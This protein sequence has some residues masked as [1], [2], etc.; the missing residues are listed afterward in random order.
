[1]RE[2]PVLKTFLQGRWTRDRRVATVSLDQLP[3]SVERY[4]TFEMKVKLYF[5]DPIK[6]GYLCTYHIFTSP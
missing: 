4:R 2:V 1:M 5:R 3:E 6:P